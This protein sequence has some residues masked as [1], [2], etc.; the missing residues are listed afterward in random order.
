M[1]AAQRGAATLPITLV[2][3]FAL[4]MAVAF[5]SRSLVFEVRSAGNQAHAAQAHE[6]AQAGLQWTLALLNN[7]TPIGA[8]CTASRDATALRWRDRLASGAL[9]ASCEHDSGGWRCHCPA[10]GAP[11]AVHDAAMP[12]FRIHLVADSATPDRWTLRSTGHSGAGNAAD[13]QM[14]VGRLPG[15]DTLPAAALTV[16]GDASFDAAFSAHHTE[17]ASG[18]VTLHAGGSVTGTELQLE[19]TPG[20]PAQA[21]L[22]SND[23]ALASLSPEA[24]HASLFRL[25]R[26]AWREQP[27]VRAVDCRS[28]CDTALREA[29]Q[30]HTRLLLVGGLR[31]DT[32]V[33]LG[34]PQRPVLLVVDG[35]VEL[36]AGAVIHGL[37]LALHGHWLDTAGATVRGAVIAAGDLQAQGASRLYHDGTVLQ[38][39]RQRTGTYAAVSGSWRDL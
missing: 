4:L 17:P 33:T 34:S 30:A 32:P 39:L 26:N 25:D 23:P 7:A 28:A 31:L 19:S 29:A 10:S 37:V 38:T 12:A 18:G 35:P 14:R 5:A 16:R 3:A 2:L 11:R 8:D 27:S 36:R 22:V 9:Q 21:S 1:N 20:T 24:L 6:A 13:L 15:L